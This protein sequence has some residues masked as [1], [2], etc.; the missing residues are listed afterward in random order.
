MAVKKVKSKQNCMGAGDCPDG[1]YCG[2]GGTCLPQKKSPGTFSGPSTKI[3]GAIIGSGLAAMG[4]Y[5]SAGKKA[6]RQKEKDEK[7]KVDNTA[8]KITSKVMKK[9]G[10][11]SDKKWIQKAINPAHKG[12]CTPMTKP[13]CTPKRK[14]LAVTLKKMAKKK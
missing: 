9:G 12:Y 10:S 11:T 6:A 4:T 8:K 3:A 1:Y 2:S 14:A 13:T 5:L 7:K